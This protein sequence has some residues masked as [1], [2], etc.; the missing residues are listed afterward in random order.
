M[1][2]VL[3]QS[4]EVK[5]REFRVEYSQAKEKEYEAEKLMEIA[6]NTGS[7]IVHMMEQAG[8]DMVKT[9]SGT[10]KILDGKLVV[11]GNTMTI[12]SSK[13][14]TGSRK[15]MSEKELEELL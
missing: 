9:F 2:G 3:L 15:K 8:L 14:T 13:K 1:S 10:A 5:I 11:N 4:L 12:A 7:N 6:N